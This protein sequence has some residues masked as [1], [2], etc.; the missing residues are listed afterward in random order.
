MSARPILIRFVVHRKHW[1][2]GQRSGLFQALT[3]ILEDESAAQLRPAILDLSKWFDANLRS[4]F[5]NSTRQSQ[6]DWK[7][8]PQSRSISWIKVASNE[9][10]SRLFQLRALVEQA[11]WQV[12]ELRTTKPER[13]LYE[14]EH[15]IVAIP[16]SDTPT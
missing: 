14:D 3:E 8:E 12:D 6:P 5:R 16:F 15:Q 7:I 10:L 2:S 13:V 4:P 9:H 1:R 11:G